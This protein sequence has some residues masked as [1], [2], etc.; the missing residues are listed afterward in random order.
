MLSSWKSAAWAAHFILERLAVLLLCI[1]AAGL[2]A[3]TLAAAAGYLPWLTLSLTFGPYHLPEAG[4][5]VQVA[6][7]ALSVA[8]CVYLP[9]IGRI[10][11]LEHAHRSFHI[12]MQDV[13]RAYHA[14]HAADRNG[15]FKLSSEFDSVRARIAHLKAHPDLGELEPGVLEVAAQMSHL[16][17]DLAETYSD[18]SVRRAE[19]F[20]IQRQQE[21]EDFNSRIEEAK[22]VA[23]SMRRWAS[24]VALEEEVARSQLER[25]RADLAE[26]L[27][28]LAEIEDAEPQSLEEAAE[29]PVERPVPVATAPEIAPQADLAATGTEGAAVPVIESAEPEWS[30]EDQAAYLEAEYGDDD[31]IV[32]L[33]SKRLR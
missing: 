19:D 3:V 22:V 33:L 28:E 2:I 12:G 20:L 24:R 26:I 30:I 17:H 7:T 29:T 23:T 25:L 5:A 10:M 18:A 1:T 27:P 21:I 32:A 15:V 6:I 11:A 31:R 9:G 4:P 14:S 16:S 8:L 13:A